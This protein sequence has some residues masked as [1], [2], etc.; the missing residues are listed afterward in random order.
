MRQAVEFGTASELIFHAGANIDLE[1]SAQRGA[2]G[3]S[4]SPTFKNSLGIVS[5]P[6]DLQSQFT[7]TNSNAG[8]RLLHYGRLSKSVS[9]RET[10]MKSYSM[11]HGQN[12][13]GVVRSLEKDV[14]GVVSA[15]S[16]IDL[17]FVSSIFVS[18]WR[19]SCI[20]LS[21]MHMSVY[22]F[23]SRKRYSCLSTSFWRVLCT[24]PHRF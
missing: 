5:S 2:A 21:F 14:V 17:A 22:D 4:G 10:S 6:R 16:S 19:G 20:H 13:D 3:L 23:N 12:S 24:P 15:H 1:Q 8:I 11:Y 9:S 18:F 7:I